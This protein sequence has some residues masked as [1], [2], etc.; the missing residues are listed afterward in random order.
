[1][2][3]QV[4]L[5]LCGKLLRGLQSR[6]RASGREISSRQI[7]TRGKVLRTD[8]LQVRQ[9]FQRLFLRQKDQPQVVVSVAV[10]GAKSQHFTELLLREIDLSV[11]CVQI[12]QVIASP[13]RFRVQ[14]KR[15][16][17]GRQRCTGILLF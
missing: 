3:L 9:S 8:T 1:M 4:V 11:R 17:K 7:E 2:Y 5:V 13:N 6:R 10:R 14:F 16:L 12:A 15:L